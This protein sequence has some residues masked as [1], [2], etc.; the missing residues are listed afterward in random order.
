M[1]TYEEYCATRYESLTYLLKLLKNIRPNK[2][3]NIIKQLYQE[4]TECVDSNL[5]FKKILG[6]QII[7][8]DEIN[9][10]W[11]PVESNFEYDTIKV[12]PKG[13]SI[14]RGLYLSGELVLKENSD[15]EYSGELDEYINMDE[16]ILEEY[17]RIERTNYLIN[18]VDEIKIDDFSYNLLNDVF[19]D[20]CGYFV[21]TQSLVLDGIEVFKNICRYKS[22]SGKSNDYDVRF[23]WIDK[24]G[25]QQQISKESRYSRNRRNDEK[26]N[27]GF[28]K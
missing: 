22:N 23:Y 20:Q 1:Y 11:I 8:K 17:K 28:G 27:W 3:K 12:S 19:I 18:H 15:I 6:H 24:E 2:S 5:K 7:T 4:Y 9:E 10:L 25:H 16:E 13:A 14:L 21:G 26:R